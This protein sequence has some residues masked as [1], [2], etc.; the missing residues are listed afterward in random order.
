MGGGGGG[1][2]T[3]VL[4]AWVA[5]GAASPSRSAIEDSLEAAG[6]PRVQQ[7]LVARSGVNAGEP[8]LMRATELLRRSSDEW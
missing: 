4:E 8:V 7:Q 1:G 5:A 2:G 3:S 6:G